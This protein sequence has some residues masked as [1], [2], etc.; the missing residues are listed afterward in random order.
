VALEAVRAAGI[1]FITPAKEV[2]FLKRGPGGDWPGAFCFPGGKQEDGET[3]EETAVRETEEEL[4]FCPD[5]K[6]AV[7]TRRISDNTCVDPQ[8]QPINP[9]PPLGEPVDYTTFIQAVPERFDPKLNGE[10]TGFAWCLATEPP[11]PLHPGARISLARLTMNELDIARAMAAGELTSP[12]RMGTFWLWNIRITGTG[13][14]F[15][16]AHKDKKG[17]VLREEEFCWR[18]KSVYLTDD[19]LARCNGLPVVFEHPDKAPK[20]DSE[21][22]NK[23]I[24]GTTFLPFIRGDDVWAVVKLYDEPTHE[25]MLTGEASTSPGVI[26][27]DAANNHLRMDDGTALL[28]EG[29]PA[30][31]DHIAVLV[32]GALGVW[33]KGGPPSGV[34]NDL[35]QLNTAKKDAAMAAVLATVVGLNTTLNRLSSRINQ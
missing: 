18:D 19:F 23:R 29:A 26:T 1:M 9:D 21:E 33:D 12:Q 14:A 7:W 6:R 15:R 35:L 32:N 5:G 2:L 27:N 24:V 17:K 31:L 13:L 25:M 34:Q 22:F 28:I 30:L 8:Q 10:H 3:L 4:G 11:E 20:L 16:G